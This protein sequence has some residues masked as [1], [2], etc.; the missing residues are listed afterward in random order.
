MNYPNIVVRLS[1]ES[2]RIVW[3]IKKGKNYPDF[4]ATVRLPTQQINE[5]VSVNG[6]FHL[7][8][9]EIGVD[10]PRGEVCVVEFRDPSSQKLFAVYK[11]KSLKVAMPN[12]IF[13]GLGSLLIY[14]ANDSIP[15]R[16]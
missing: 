14:T 7:R 1:K 15:I 3:T 2:L 12:K 11:P 8:G 6:G 5:Y 13:G 10:A 16:C 4:L 9:N